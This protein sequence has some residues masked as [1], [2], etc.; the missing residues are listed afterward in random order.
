[1]A[2][3]RADIRE[4]APP[5]AGTDGPDGAWEA[6]GA[7]LDEEDTSWFDSPAWQAGEAEV[8]E[9]IRAGCVKRYRSV[10]ELIKDLRRAAG[11]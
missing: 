5:L 7:E 9:H 2:E 8:D 6:D 4:P 11:E 10:A 3:E 1:M